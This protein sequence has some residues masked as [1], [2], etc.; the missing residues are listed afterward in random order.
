MNH[1]LGSVRLALQFLTRIPLPGPAASGTLESKDLARSV[2]AFPLVGAILGGVLVCLDLTVGRELPRLA[3]DGLL[4]TAVVLLTGGMHL[5]GLMDTVDGLFGGRSAERRLEIM[6][7][8]RVGSYGVQAGILA[9]VLKLGLLSGFEPG[10][11]AG[12]LVAFPACGRWAMTIVMGHYPYARE[13]GGLGRAFASS[14]GASERAAA[15]G[16]VLGIFGGAALL[17]LPLLYSFLAAAAAGLAAHALA[18]ISTRLAGGV[19]GDVFGATN[20]LAEFV[21]LLVLSLAQR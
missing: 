19:T 9:I 3:A 7:D 13:A 5:D 16:V 14:V 12:L 15:T 2:P 6:R 17:G 18:R 1:W 21:F 8:S 4:L 20:E 10:A 11:R